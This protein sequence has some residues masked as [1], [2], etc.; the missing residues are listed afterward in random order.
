MERRN[1]VAQE[2][3][4]EQR[5]SWIDLNTI[6]AKVIFTI[7]SI[8]LFG[9]IWELAAKLINN[10]VILPTP[11]S[12]FKALYLLIQNKIPPGAAGVG[13]FESML[14]QTL[15]ITAIG[16]LLS[17]AV[18]I[19]IGYLIGR[20]RAA[21]AIIDPWIN[22]LYAIPMVAL[23]PLLYFGSGSLIPVS[24]FDY[25][26]DLLPDVLVSFI[27][28]VFTIIINTY[29]GVRL[30]SNSLVEVGKAFGASEN[31]LTR[32][33]V[34]PAALPDIVAGMRLGLGRALL[35]AI[36]AEA[37]LSTNGLGYAMLAFQS[38]LNTPYMVA[39][40]M[41]IAFIGFVLLQTPKLIE[42]RLFKWKET[43]RIKRGGNE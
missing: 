22:A 24:V 3:I 19:P 5:E 41:V 32:H 10:H 4:V 30:V 8:L 16:F 15:E 11:I 42:R 2:V 39:T 12:S 27:M 21:E 25:Q 14:L 35:G 36:I 29:Q 40:I 43:E 13:S 17:S 7:V 37:L 33:V 31:Q 20:W 38:I 9:A 18:G 1:L 26:G 28:A 6:Q 34:I 23:I